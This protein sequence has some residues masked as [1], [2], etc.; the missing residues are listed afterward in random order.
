MSLPDYREMPLSRHRRP[1]NAGL[2]AKTLKLPTVTATAGSATQFCGVQMALAKFHAF[3]L[4]ESV[5]WVKMQNLFHNNTSIGERNSLPIDQSASRFGRTSVVLAAA[6]PL[7]ALLLW[8]FL[9]NIAA[10]VTLMLVGPAIAI[11]WRHLNWRTLAQTPALWCFWGG[12]ILLA[13]S[14]LLQPGLPS[15][16]FIGDFLPFAL[17]PLFALALAPLQ[18]TR[19]NLGHLSLICFVA[20]VLAAG[21]GLH[22]L[23]VGEARA[24]APGFSPIHF[25]VFSTVFGFMSLGFTLSGNS[26]WRWLLLAGPFFGVAASMASGTKATMI[27]GCALA[28]VYGWFWMRRRALPFWARIATPLAMAAVVVLSVYLASLVGIGRPFEAIKATAGIV[29]GDLNGD[30][31]TIYRVEMARAGWLAFLHNWT[32]GDG[33]SSQVTAA[34]P[35]FSPVGLQ[36]YANERW[37]YLHNDALNFAVAAGLPGFVAYCLFLLAPLRAAGSRQRSPALDVRLY[38]A[39]TCVI[40]LLIGGMTDAL[41][42]VEMPKVFLTVITGLLFFLDTDPKQQDKIPDRQLS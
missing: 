15:I 16:A 27:V 20:S 11:S 28:L 3:D 35:Y 17:M 26:P 30:L 40:G 13:A 21:V 10:Y 7:P 1:A 22:G 19:I 5:Y 37:G 32:V 9:G 33:W 14:F 6:T 38:L 31:S 39:F 18:R 2:C 24:S 34:M 23:T 12:F 41:F 25:A 36:G 4:A 29:T 8:P 42:T